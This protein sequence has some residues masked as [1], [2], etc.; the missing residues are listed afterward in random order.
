MVSIAHRHAFVEN[1]DKELTIHFNKVNFELRVP[2][3]VHI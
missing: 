1:I 2:K 3:K